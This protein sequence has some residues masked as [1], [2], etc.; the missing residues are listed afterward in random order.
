ML[1]RTILLLSVCGF[2]FGAAA[3]LSGFSTRKNQ[4]GHNYI[5]AG[6]EK[7]LYYWNYRDKPEILW[8]NSGPYSEIKKILPVPYGLFILSTAGIHFSSDIKNF[9]AVNDGLN[10]KI[11]KYYNGTKSF[12]N[13][14]QDL[15]D[16]E[17]DPSNPSN[18]ITCSKE[19][20]FYTTNAGNLWQ[21]IPNPTRVPGIKAVGIF[22]ETDLKV[23]AALPFK[24]LY[25]KNITKGTPWQE[26]D[27]GLLEY[28]KAMEEVSS[29]VI[30]KNEYGIKIFTANNFTPSIYQINPDAKEWKPI[31][32]PNNGFNLIESLNFDDG[33]FYFL[34]KEGLMHWNTNESSAEKVDISPMV[35]AFRT[36][37]GLPIQ[38]LCLF[39]NGNVE[40]N[41]SECWLLNEPAQS[42]YAKTA[43]GK[44][45]IYVSAGTIKSPNRLAKVL[46]LMT[47][48]GLNSMVIDMKD[49]MGNLRF[50]PQ[51]DILKKMGRV[52][53]P[54]DIDAFTPEMKKRGIYLIARL[55]LFQDR[56]LYEY[57][58]HELAIKDRTT[59]KAW[60]EIKTKKDGT[61]KLIDEYWVD[62][63][64]EKA[65]EYNAA[66]GKELIARGFDEIQFDYVRFPTD[67]DNLEETFYSFRDKGMDK[68]SAIMSFLNYARQNIPAPIS[69]D[70]YGANGWW[71]TSARTGQDVELFRRY[72]DAICPMYYPSH[73]DADFLNYEPY[74]QRP[75][76]IYY[77]GSYRNYYIGRKSIVVRPYVQAFNMHT[78]YDRKFYGASYIAGEVK[79]VN[80]SIGLGYTFWN[81][82]V[83]YELLN[84]VFKKK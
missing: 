50:K 9:R 31:Y 60:I 26:W 30:D 46:T 72:V 44:K 84:E 12:S 8:G 58:N 81:M 3:V 61:R 40:Y 66:I 57:N 25:V 77:F 45:G 21:F 32:R 69:I 42:A 11:I 16:L 52:A 27:K 39:S 6:T 49:D 65:W 73:F 37:T 74:D 29:V 47:N 20:I 55:V 76:R 23:I 54:I 75:F 79:G 34:T 28:S 83:K 82:G 43:S 70:I 78:A 53:G 67:G 71:R 19:G 68:E 7:G 15:K 24:G 56:V 38:S 18:L 2:I 22:S 35:N 41:L 5:L 80:E 4:P 59:K 63:Y 51:S 13:E 17:A 62:P 36:S 33:A 14:I 1:K 48:T 64:S 10:V